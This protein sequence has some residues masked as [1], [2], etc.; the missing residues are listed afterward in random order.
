[1]A[2]QY[3]VRLSARALVLQPFSTP[4]KRAVAPPFSFIPSWTSVLT[5]KQGC[6][7]TRE[8][9]VKAHIVLGTYLIARPE[10]YQRFVAALCWHRWRRAFWSLM[11]RTAIGFTG[12]LLQCC[13]CGLAFQLLNLALIKWVLSCLYAHS[14]VRL[15]LVLSISFGEPH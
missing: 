14:V 4:R 12:T 10:H 5:L 13:L 15:L 9:G 11:L 1:M 6:V 7:G 2:W 8:L 3:F